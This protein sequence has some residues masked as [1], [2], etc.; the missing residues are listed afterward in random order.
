M[1]SALALA[2]AVLSPA[3]V[4]DA[5]GHPRV[6]VLSDIGNEP[7]D[8]MSLVRLLL[9]SDGIDIEG[10]AAVTS[11]FQKTATHPETMRALVAAYGAVRPSLL[12]HAPGWPAAA[13]LAAR[14]SSGPRGYGMAATD[15]A[16]P[17]AAARA[18]V[19]AADRAEA[20]PLWVSVWGGA[21]VLA[22]ALAHVRATR[23]AAALARFVA[24]LRIYAISDQDDAG[25]WI[26]REFPALF[27]V[28][29]P[30][31]PD[32]GD[33]AAA[34]WTG[35]SGD[36]Y[37]MNGEGADF[38]TVSNE[39]LDAH[40]RG[41][42]A[43]GRHYPRYLFIMEGDTPAFLALI[44]NGLAAWRSPAW[45]GWGGRYVY[46]QPHGETR[47]MWTQGGDLFF[48]VASRDS[49]TG[50]DGA[51]HSSDQATIW[52]WRTAFQH[53]FAA[54]MDWTVK[55]YAAANHPPAPAVDGARG[56][57]V[58]TRT[59]RAGETL[60][61]DAGAS[62]DPDGDALTYRWFAYPEAGGG[63]GASLADVRVDAAGARATVTAVA[64]CRPGWVAEMTP[65]CPAEGQAH[66]ILAVRDDGAPSLT[67]YRRVIV[68]V[69]R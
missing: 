37:Y 23:D 54:R 12:R 44:D 2:A 38:S 40:I 22:E 10:L 16:H 4:D 32:S 52:R 30:S 55:P 7:D 64:T 63:T 36:R 9:Y 59:M 3:Q 26:R 27:W 42:G 60:V 14:I 29:Q 11:T 20:R 13:A 66:L 21:N 65:P 47:A 39:W 6:F 69:R 8:Q 50:S 41:K 45:G 33:Y 1:L 62:S 18:L 24:A 28:G 17:S 51:A 19:A 61:L 49:V 34:T 56:L 46:R 58:V 68:T 53:D 31:S 48:R 5:P 67:R 15:P 43:L 35:I 25:P 57:G